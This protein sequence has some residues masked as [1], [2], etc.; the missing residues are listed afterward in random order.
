MHLANAIATLTVIVLIGAFIAIVLRTPEQ[1]R[2]EVQD[3]ALAWGEWKRVYN[4]IMCKTK[5]SSKEKYRSDGRCPKCNYRHPQ[6]GTVVVTNDKW[7]RINKRTNE[8]ETKP[9]RLL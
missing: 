9:T 5:L 7:I 6:T 1:E 2:E 4:C 8:I 3:L